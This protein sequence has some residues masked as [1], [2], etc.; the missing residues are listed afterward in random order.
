MD[1]LYQF[2]VLQL[3]IGF[4]C[5]LSDSG[6]AVI[7]RMRMRSTRPGFSSYLKDMDTLYHTQ[8]HRLFIGHG[9]ALPDPGSS[10]IYRIWCA[11]PDPGSTV[12]YRIWVRLTS[13]GFGSYL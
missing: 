12:I 11:L 1:A 3:L 7:Y 5:A 13:H 10:V 4:G 9:Y 8:V 2:W 6:S